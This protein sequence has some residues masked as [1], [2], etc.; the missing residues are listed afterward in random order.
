M[1]EHPA[2]NP[3]EPPTS[4][5]ATRVVA[6]VLLL[7]VIAGAGVWAARS[8]SAGALDGTSWRLIGGT[9][10]ARFEGGEIS[11]DGPVNLYS[12]EY[13]A[14]RDGSFSVGA[15]TMTERGASPELMQAEADFF[16][17]LDAAERYAVEGDALALYG[18]N[19]DQLLR[20]E[21][22]Q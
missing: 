7:A 18:G 3:N 5:G 21:R 20:F 10:T 17:A 16:S 9:A 6:L 4:W 15:L 22:V 8:G 1:A 13:E 11:G 2:H 14:K 12:G 19:G